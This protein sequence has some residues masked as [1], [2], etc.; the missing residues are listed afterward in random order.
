MLIYNYGNGVVVTPL[1]MTV[2]RSTDRGDFVYKAKELW[3]VAAI[4]TFIA[5]VLG[6]AAWM[7]HTYSYDATDL[8]YRVSA[9]CHGMR[10]SFICDSNDIVS[11]NMGADYW[12]QAII[13]TFLILGMLAAILAAVYSI[14]MLIGMTYKDWKQRENAARVREAALVARIQK[15]ETA[16]FYSRMNMALLMAKTSQSA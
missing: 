10:D 12:F 3:S 4:A 14:A 16:L 13:I 2:Y 9:A 8:A 6:S 1:K 7:I 5:A 15:A 11:R